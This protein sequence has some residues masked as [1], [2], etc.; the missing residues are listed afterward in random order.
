VAAGVASSGLGLLGRRQQRRWRDN[1]DPLDGRTPRFPDGTVR[2]VTTG[3]GAQ[4]HTVRAGSGPPVLLVHGLTASSEDWGPVAERLVDQGLEVVAVDQRGHGRSTLGR[5]PFSPR[6]LGD[7]LAQV[8][9]ALDLDRLVVV[10]HSMGGMA[11]L[12]LA[13]GHPGLLADRVVGLVLVST[14]ARIAGLRNR[15]SIPIAAQ[16]PATVPAALNDSTLVLGAVAL[17]AVGPHPSLNL[18]RQ[19]V[20]SYTRC[21]EAT[22]QKA[23]AGLAGFD[24]SGQISAISV[25][26]LVLSGRHD[27]LVPFHDSEQIAASIPGAVLVPI[28]G[29]GHLVPWE[30]PDEL[31]RHIAGSAQRA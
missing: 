10:G 16:L 26:T 22:R 4:L 1:P 21:P 24:V 30:R 3:D 7:D 9:E 25:P 2:S 19:S 31:A 28:E 13:V 23:T 8:I 20:S 27:L 14:T 6:Q 18:L 11:A 15:L 17:S 5:A 12:S 29:A